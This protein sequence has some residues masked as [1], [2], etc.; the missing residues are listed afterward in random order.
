VVF[1]DVSDAPGAARSEPPTGGPRC[2][3]STRRQEAPV[4]RG[5]VGEPLRVD[6]IKVP[7]GERTIWKQLA[8]PD[9]AGVVS[10]GKGG[11]FAITADGRSYAYSYERALSTLYLVDGLQ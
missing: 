5:A 3:I 2:D 10:P 6:R 4:R 7:S 8:P 11:Y 1:E 9:L